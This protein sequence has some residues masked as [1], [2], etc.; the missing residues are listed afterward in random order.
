MPPEPAQTLD[1]VGHPGQSLVYWEKVFRLII[2]WIKGTGRLVTEAIPVY[3][4]LLVGDAG[5]GKTCLVRR[6]CENKF[7]EARIETIGV[8]FQSKVIA[9]NTDETVCLV[10]WDIAGQDRFKSFRDQYYSGALAIGLVYDV[11]NPDSF[12]HLAEWQQEAA[13]FAPGTPMALIGN[14]IDRADVVPPKEAKNWAT[15]IDSPF[16]RVSALSGENVEVAFKYLA[17][18]ANSYYQDLQNLESPFDF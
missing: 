8:D 12:Y 14:K 5:V 13:R 4:V 6:Y 1:K 17:Q 18:M 16:L 9:L 10:L 2:L 7:R 11:T 3:K 15:M